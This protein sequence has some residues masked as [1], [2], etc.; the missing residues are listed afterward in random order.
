MVRCDV[1]MTETEVLPSVTPVDAVIT[2]PVWPNA[3]PKLV[4]SDDPAGLSQRYQ[5]LVDWKYIH[6]LSASEME[7]MERLGTRLDEHYAPY[8]ERLL[9][10][11]RRRRI[12]RSIAALAH[13]VVVLVQVAAIPLGCLLL[14]TLVA[15]IAAG[16][17]DAVPVSPLAMWARGALIGVLMLLAGAIGYAWRG[18]R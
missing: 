13:L 15:W 18:G 14:G 11:L 5:Q 8:Y 17:P 9:A 12:G 3:S 16:G 1:R 2:D 7:E 6:G 10:D 4:G